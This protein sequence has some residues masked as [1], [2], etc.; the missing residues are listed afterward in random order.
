MSK[1]SWFP[2]ALVTILAVSAGPALSMFRRTGKTIPVVRLL[3]NMKVHIEKYPKDARAQ[4]V[5]ARIHAM[6]WATGS[7]T[8][9]MTPATPDEDVP[10]SERGKSLPRFPAY[11]SVLRARVMKAPPKPAARAHFHA[12]VTHYRRS[13]KLDPKV[14]ITHLGL[15]WVLD[16]GA[17]WSHVLKLPDGS[18]TKAKW[19]PGEKEKLQELLRKAA[20]GVSTAEREAALKSLR[21]QLP[22][23]T[24]FALERVEHA[25]EKPALRRVAKAL[26]RRR[27]EELSLASYRK[28]YAL[29]KDV[30]L[31]KD[32]FGPHADSMLALEAGKAI[33]RLLDGRKEPA[34][35]KESAAVNAVLRTIRLK[36]RSIT[37]IV[38]PVDRPR[39]LEALLPEGA[40]ARF[41]LDGDDII[42]NWPWVSAD[43]GIL[44]WAP[45]PNVPVTS[46]RQLFGSVTW[47]IPWR[48]GYEPLR[49]LDDNQDG[50]LTGD[51][52]TGIAVWRDINS[53]AVA[54]PSEVTPAAEFGIESIRVT[55]DHQ[56][57][58]VP[59]ARAGIHM[60]DGRVLPTYD[61]TPRSLPEPDR[62][63]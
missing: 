32:F 33:V 26:L 47:W 7:P 35:L 48:N 21:A 19:L 22:R 50:R 63:P 24:L 42:E 18:E 11:R 56:H 61:W 13:L 20:A 8:L 1:H 58:G 36:G 59:A 27:Y 3:D 14:A 15:A 9:H 52:L 46:G 34:A 43:T 31:K 55:A 54:A 17:Q 29:R 53:D 30:E 60:Q 40:S 6:V 4:M 57:A 28:A 41:D 51:E 38:F 10:E 45:D 12:A 23:A 37:P 49:A 2:L 39:P 25:D 62:R 44:V 5:V 16:D